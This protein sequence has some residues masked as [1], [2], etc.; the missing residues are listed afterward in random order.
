M[1]GERV[2]VTEAVM[3]IRAAGYVV[4]QREGQEREEQPQRQ[5]DRTLVESEVLRELTC[6]HRTEKGE[7]EEGDSRR[8]AAQPGGK[9]VETV[10]PEPAADFVIVGEQRGV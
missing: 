1:S 10:Q 6:H 7:A 2:A 8:Q 9:A 5:G 4:H 3:H